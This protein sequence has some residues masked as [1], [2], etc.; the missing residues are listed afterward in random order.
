MDESFDPSSRQLEDWVQ[1]ESA[2]AHYDP[3]LYLS[4][5][6]M[7]SI[8]YQFR[9]LHKH[10]P[11]GK[12]LEVGVGSGLAAQLLRQLGHTVETLDVDQRLNP[13]VLGSVTEIPCADKSFESFTCCQVLEH[14][15]WEIVPTALSELQRISSAGG[16]ISVP[17]NQ[18]SLGISLH[19]Y[20]YCGSRRIHLPK[21][22]K[23]RIRTRPEHHWELEA[24]ISTKQ[25]ESEIEKAGFRLIYDIQPVQNFFHHFFVIER[26]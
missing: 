14:L 3:M 25:F 4:P 12:V 7:A 22:R 17:T 24:N 9:L 2:A 18:P 26:S 1:V 5:Q 13:D 10:F 19:N 6:R 23:Q 16:V 20:N 11:H 8:G 15:P 21:L